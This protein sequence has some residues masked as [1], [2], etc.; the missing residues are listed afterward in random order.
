MSVKCLTPA[1]KDSIIG[2]Y[3]AKHLNIKQLAKNFNTSPRT[4]GRVLED[5]GLAT[6]VPRLKGE[7][8]LILGLLKEH[9]IDTPDQLRNH[10]AQP[11]VNPNTV[12]AYLQGMSKEALLNLLYT[13]ITQHK[14]YASNPALFK[15]NTV[16]DERFA[17]CA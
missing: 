11:L 2:F 15:P 9:G 13:A 7:A 4:I 17:L 8:Y 5:A 12:Q 6:P 10:L 16:F 1:D 14:N 3:K